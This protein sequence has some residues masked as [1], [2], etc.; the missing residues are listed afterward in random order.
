[1]NILKWPEFTTLGWL[2][3]LVPVA[4]MQVIRL[5]TFIGVFG[6]PVDETA[7]TAGVLLNGFNPFILAC[8]L[9][10]FLAPW[11]MAMFFVYHQPLLIR[12]V[13]TVSLLMVW[14][15]QSFLFI[16]SWPDFWTYADDMMGFTLLFNMVITTVIA[17]ALMVLLLLLF[18]VYHFVQSRKLPLAVKR[19][20]Q[21]G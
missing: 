1:M 5:V 4:G 17:I 15:F 14:L 10:P 12:Q 18:G 16:A 9:I 19:I 11:G 20:K 8:V 21:Y 2:T 3:L 6:W 7:W 13:L